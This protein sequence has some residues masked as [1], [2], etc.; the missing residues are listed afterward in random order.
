MRAVGDVFVD[1][2]KVPARQAH[3]SHG[4]G[5]AEPCQFGIKGIQ[6]HGSGPLTGMYVEN[7]LGNDRP[8]AAFKGAAVSG[9]RRYVLMVA[10]D[11]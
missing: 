7:L 2:H 6:L 9:Q 8:R 4:S 11:V 1:K 5:E 10:F 3:F